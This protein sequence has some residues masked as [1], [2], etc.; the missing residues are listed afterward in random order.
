MTPA[1]LQEQ[2]QS[3][4]LGSSTS[5]GDIVDSNASFDY[6][7]AAST[8][9]Q[10]MDI[11]DFEAKW[12]D[13]PDKYFL[14]IAHF[15]TGH[16]NDT[17]AIDRF[18]GPILKASIKNVYWIFLIQYAILAMMGIVMNIAIIAYIVYHRLYRDV[19]HAFIIN[20]AF[21]HFVQCA[22]VLPVTLMVM[23]IQNWIFGQFLCFFLPMLQ[24]S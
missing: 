19:T 17:D 6:H 14:I 22:V 20:L 21:C 11:A 24:V 23:L 5:S 12:K 13:V 15:L 9:N 10:K 1:L 3:I 7:V 16:Y 4:P 8:G 2:Q 18:N